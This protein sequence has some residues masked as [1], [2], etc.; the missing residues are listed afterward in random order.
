MQIKKLPDLNT[1]AVLSDFVFDAHNADLSEL[2]KRYR[3]TLVTDGGSTVTAW[4]KSIYHFGGLTREVPIVI[5][6]KIG[7]D[8]CI[9]SLDIDRRSNG[10]QGARC[11]FPCLEQ[12]IGS[13]LIGKKI[14]DIPELFQSAADTKCLH[15]YEILAGAASFC[16]HLEGLGLHDGSEQELFAIT[17]TKTG[18][19]VDATHEVLGEQ[20][21]TELVVRY[22]NAPVLN[23]FNLPESVSGSVLVRLDGAAV[24]TEKLNADSFEMIYAQLNRLASRCYNLE[25][26]RFGLSGRVKFSNCPSMSGLLLLAMSHQALKG[27]VGRAIEVERILH[28]LQTGYHANPC[29]GF[30]G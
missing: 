3:G 13:K 23:K 11:S 15:I 29:K 21:E 17:P 6:L 12:C 2:I 20:S 24:R 22:E 5:T 30:G 26:K 27:T 19:L 8:G 10:S 4:Q 18:L 7:G 14:S 25:K 9:A 28:Y 1:V 16:A